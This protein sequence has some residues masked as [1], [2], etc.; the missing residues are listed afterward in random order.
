MCQKRAG[1]ALSSMRQSGSCIM[2]DWKKSRT[3]DLCEANKTKLIARKIISGA[4]PEVSCARIKN[5][6]FVCLWCE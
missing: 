2:N 3:G 5:C 4:N 6:A 1:G